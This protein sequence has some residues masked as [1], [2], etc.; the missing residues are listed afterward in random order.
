[1]FLR[2]SSEMNRKIYAQGGNNNNNSYDSKKLEST[3]MDSYLY[4]ELVK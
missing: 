3:Y 4:G 1:M 2:K